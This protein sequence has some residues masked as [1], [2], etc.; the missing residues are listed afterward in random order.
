MKDQR[1]E[2]ALDPAPFLAVIAQEKD[3]PVLENPVTV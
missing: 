3:L 2:G 1:G